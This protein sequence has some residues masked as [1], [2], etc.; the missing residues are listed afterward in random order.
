MA[1]KDEDNKSKAQQTREAMRS[2]TAQGTEERDDAATERATANQNPVGDTGMQ[3]DYDP[4]GQIMQPGQPLH[5]TDPEE[6]R[7]FEEQRQE[8]IRR[9][10]SGEAV[11]DEQEE[12]RNRRENTAPGDDKK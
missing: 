10:Q 3:A 11:M 2:D 9:A 6:Q 12:R 1:K 7:K 4:T 8:D 5:S